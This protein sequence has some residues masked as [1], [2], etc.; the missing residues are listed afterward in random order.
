MIT[1]PRTE[2]GKKKEKHKEKKK[3]HTQHK[4]FQKLRNYQCHNK[5]SYLFP[6]Q[7]K[8]VILSREHF[9]EFPIKEKSHVFID[10]F[11]F[12][13]YQTELWEKSGGKTPVVTVQL[14]SPDYCYKFTFH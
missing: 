11:S 7:F 10:L 14:L 13:L 2:K 1:L 8:Y 9:L 4:S 6:L 5:N 12:S 3:P